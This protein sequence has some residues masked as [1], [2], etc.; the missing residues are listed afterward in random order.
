MTMRPFLLAKTP[1]VRRPDYGFLAVPLTH[2]ASISPSILRLPFRVLV[3]R[4]S[5][6]R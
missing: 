3:D 2:R 6:K 4:S 1:R 5:D